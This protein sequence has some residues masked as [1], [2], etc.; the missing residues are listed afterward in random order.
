MAKIRVANYTFDASAQTITFDDYGAITLDAVLLVT[1][2]TDNII[3]Y[4]F[5]NS[6]LGGTAATNVL[7]LTYDTTSMS[8]TDDL[9]IFYE[10]TTVSIDTADLALESGGNLATIAG[11]TTSIDGKVTACDTGAVV[12]ASGAITETNSA[13][14]AGDTTSIDGKITACD[15]GAV[16]V[17]SSA[18]PAGAATAALQLPDGHNVTIDNAVGAAAV[19]IQDGGNTI[20]VDGTVTETNSAT[21]AGDTTSIDGKITA[22]DTG[23]VVVSSGAITETNSATIAGDTTSIDGKITACDTG[24]VVISS[25]TVI[26]TYTAP[27][28][29]T[30]AAYEASSVSK[31]SAGTLWGFSGYNSKSS[32]Q[33]IQVHDASSLP[34]DTA[35][36]EVIL[37]ADASGSFSYDAG[38][39]GRSFGTGIVICNSSTGPTKTIGSAD[40]W[41]DVQYT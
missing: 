38:I 19:N 40:C 14:I 26:A 5:A 37:Y 20:T 17:S 22:C 12:V 25:G 21:I 6:L 28:N 27:S 16:V 9:Q 39:R 34:A 23:A 36:P 8:D 31:A 24:A 15:T 33:F 32:A 7:T 10:D 1:N 30:S 11:D 35:V 29:D 3:I 41:F 4:N 18:L 2:V 13:T